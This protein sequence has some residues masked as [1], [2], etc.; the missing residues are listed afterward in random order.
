MKKKI[1]IIAAVTALLAMAIPAFAAATNGL[2]Q[3][4]ATKINA[5][6]Q[7]MIELRMQMVDEYQS[8]GQITE[9]QAATIKN[10]I[11]NHLD[12]LENNPDT[13]TGPGMGR[14]MGRGF[15]GGGFCGNCPNWQQPVPQN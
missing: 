6:Q 9:E 7:Q 1:F 14:G 10:N 8:A 15:G 2:T 5:L 12:Y 11:Q 3:E 13:T 4:Q